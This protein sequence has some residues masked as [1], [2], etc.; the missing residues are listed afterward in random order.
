MSSTQTLKNDQLWAKFFEF[1]DKHQLEDR[2]QNW[3]RALKNLPKPTHK[4]C[5]K[6]SPLRSLGRKVGRKAVA[7]AD[8][9][10]AGAKSAVNEGQGRASKSK[11]NRGRRIDTFDD[12]IDTFR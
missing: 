8:G 10:S 4:K 5:F 11:Q 3:R 9:E 2:A 12:P 6:I 7:K 1:V